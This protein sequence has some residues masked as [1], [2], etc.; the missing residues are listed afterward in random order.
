MGVRLP[1]PG[2]L[3]VQLA[4]ARQALAHSGTGYLPAWEQLTDEQRE[5][6]ALEARHY[7]DAAAQA[8]IAVAVVNA[9][10]LPSPARL[11][12]TIRGVGDKPIERDDYASH[13]RARAERGRQAERL[14]LLAEEEAVAVAGLL[15]EIAGVYCDE[16]LGRLAREL[17]VRI[18]DRLGI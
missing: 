10:E 16:H 18:Y 13:L 6:A 7:L 11:T 2:E 9:D 8:G 15:D 3:A 17:A 14:P 12:A 4:R 5:F 1:D